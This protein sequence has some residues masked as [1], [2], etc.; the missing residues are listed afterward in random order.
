[1]IRRLLFQSF[2][3]LAVLTVITGVAY[4][5]LVTGVAQAAFPRQ[6][7]GSLIV[8]DGQVVAEVADTGSG[9]PPEHLARIYDPFFTTKAIG[10]GTGLGLSI[11]YGIVHE[12]DGSIRC[13]RTDG[14]IKRSAITKTNDELR[15]RLQACFDDARQW[16]AARMGQT[17]P[18]SGGQSGERV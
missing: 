14:T 4:P 6:A 5:L 15:V 1:M 7:N 12:H 16:S 10:R 2:G 18:D 8:K 9:I 17:M 3:M 11:T 13:D